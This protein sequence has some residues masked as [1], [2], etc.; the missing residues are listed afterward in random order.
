M[1]ETFKQ[2]LIAHG[3]AFKRTARG[4]HPL[5]EHPERGTVSISIRAG[6]QQ[7]ARCVERRLF[8]F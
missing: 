3:W 5:W 6:R 1:R 7:V 4:S 8:G 2:K